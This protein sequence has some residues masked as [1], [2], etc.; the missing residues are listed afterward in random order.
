M[1]GINSIC[2]LSYHQILAFNALCTPQNQVAPGA[3]ISPTDWAFPL[4]VFIGYA[5]IVN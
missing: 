2:L 3:L 1:I 5:K 4:T